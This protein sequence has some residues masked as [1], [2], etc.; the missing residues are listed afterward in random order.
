MALAME[1]KSQRFNLISPE[2]AT[3]LQSAYNDSLFGPLYI[4]NGDNWYYSGSIIPQRTLAVNHIVRD[5][6]IAEQERNGVGFGESG[7]KRD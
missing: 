1:A 6:T 3:F 2:S 5:S 7:M 4:S